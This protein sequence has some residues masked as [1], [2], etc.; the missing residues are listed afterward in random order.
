MSNVAMDAAQYPANSSRHDAIR[1]STPHKTGLPS[2]T[3]VMLDTETAM[4][5]WARGHSDRDHDHD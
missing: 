1:P 3:S 2:A 5:A 4:S